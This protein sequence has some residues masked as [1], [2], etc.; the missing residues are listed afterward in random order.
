MKNRPQ[1]LLTGASGA[2]GQ[3]VLRQLYLRRADFDITVFDKKSKTSLKILTPYKKGIEIVYGDIT[4][5]ENVKKICINKDFFIHLAAIIPP[6]ADKKPALAYRVNVTG[7]ENLVRALEQFSPHAFLIYSSSVSV[8]GDR[9]DNPH[10]TVNDPLKPSKGDEYAKTK[11]EAEQIIRSS[12]I[13]WTIFRLSAIMGKHKISELM[14][15][16]PLNTCMEIATPEDTARAFINAFDKRTLISKRI[17]NL[18]G[19]DCCRITYKDFLTRSFK[20]FGLGKLNFPPKAF[21]EKNFHCGFFDDGDKLNN[22]LHFRN[23]TIES[24][25]T[26]VEKSVTRLKRNTTYLFSPSIKY[27]LLLKSEPYKAS[28]S[29]NSKSYSLYFKTPTK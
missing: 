10:I 18:G 8:Y 1:I 24:Y 26:G 12:R 7:T 16:M 17:F 4:N 25:F 28:R 11:I 23:D 5:L 9:L 20:I 15:H 29:R 14:F 27:I 6:L 13:D 22:I 2:V 3:E 19:G 21:A